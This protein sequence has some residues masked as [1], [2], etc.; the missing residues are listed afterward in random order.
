MAPPT[1]TA[2]VPVN[3]SLMKN[4]EIMRIIDQSALELELCEEDVEKEKARWA[5]GGTPQ[6]LAVV[7][8]ID[9]VHTGHK[10]VDIQTVISRGGL[11]AKYTTSKMPAL[12][13][14][15]PFAREVSMRVWHDGEMVLRAG[16]FPSQWK[17]HL[18]SGYTFDR[19]GDAVS[20]TAVATIPTMPPE[21][22]SVAKK[23]HILLWEPEW[24]KQ[25]AQ[26]QR[27]PRDPALLERLSGNLYV[28]LATWDLSE[29]E[30]AALA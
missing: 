12:A 17:T 21:I 26:V 23:D 14:A 8:A 25:N 18:Q 22:R 1:S 2:L 3:Q 13:I 29:L 5:A 6:D 19:S 20:Y 27:P 11:S 24:R 28:V 7:K 9:A 4:N 15:P 30:A 10:L 16:R